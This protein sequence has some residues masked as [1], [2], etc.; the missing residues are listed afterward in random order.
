MKNKSSLELSLFSNEL[1]LLLVLL[2]QEGDTRHIHDPAFDSMD[3]SLFLQLTRHHR[4]YPSIYR[5]LKEQPDHRI[6]TFVVQRLQRDSSRNTF[7]ML[8]LSGEMER[9]SRLLTENNIRSLALKGPTLAVDLYGD[10]SLRTSSDLDILVPIHDLEK[11]DDILISHGYEREDQLS[12]VLKEWS[13]RHHHVNYSHPQ[14][15]IK[16][17]IH[18]RLNPGPSLD[19]SFEQ[20]WERRRISPLTSYPIYVLGTEDLFLFLISH[21]ARH[22]WSRLRWLEDIDRMVRSQVDYEK[23]RLLL[24]KYQYQHI[25]GQSL[26]LASELLHTPICGL[27]PVT[28]RSK[29]LAQEALFYIKQMV[30]LHTDPVPLEIASYHKRHLFSLMSTRQKLL[31][32]VST[33][34]PY[35]VDVE[36]LPLPKTFHFLYFPLRPVLWAWR[37]AQRRA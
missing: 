3:W 2:Q 10:I 30:N 28:D 20:L 5:R 35:P 19:P 4:V 23:L 12:K 29:R 14:K 33:L 13:W 24:S 1:R 7:H 26:H 11:I 36:T 16:L 15:K 32:M 37:K 9:V 25:G 34:Y 17:E 31:F 22:G 18:W 6:P 27:L 21:G 8:H